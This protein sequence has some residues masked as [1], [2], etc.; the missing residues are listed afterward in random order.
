MACQY[1]PH[2][3]YRKHNHLTCSVVVHPRPGSG[4][5][6]RSPLVSPASKLAPT[7]PSLFSRLAR[8]TV[9]AQA[10]TGFLTPAPRL[11]PMASSA[12]VGVPRRYRKLC[13]LYIN[14]PC[15]SSGIRRAVIVCVLSKVGPR[16]T[17]PIEYRAALSGQSG[18]KRRS[19]VIWPE[20]G[21]RCAPHRCRTGP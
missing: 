7:Q 9:P 10:S 18:K 2:A 16:T 13:F 19:D 15:P 8:E 3:Q 1:K 4:L 6:F 14:H 11:S 20:P 5:G 17:P 12:R 21:S